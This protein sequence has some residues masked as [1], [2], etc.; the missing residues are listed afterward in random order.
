M[1]VLDDYTS[2]DIVQLDHTYLPEVAKMIV[3]FHRSLEGAD[4]PQE[5]KA[6]LVR[7]LATSLSTPDTFGGLSALKAAVAHGLQ[8]ITLHVH[9]GKTESELDKILATSWNLTLTPDMI[10]HDG[11]GFRTSG[12]FVV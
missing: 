12:H 2:G 6:R 11:F 3:V 7:N 1:A 10:T 9:M 8:V 5:K 4:L